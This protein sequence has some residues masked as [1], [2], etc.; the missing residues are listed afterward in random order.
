MRRAALSLRFQSFRYRVRH[1][2]DTLSVAG[3]HCDETA[4]LLTC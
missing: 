3:R 2:K 4:D 1:G